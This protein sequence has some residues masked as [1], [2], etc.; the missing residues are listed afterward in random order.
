MMSIVKGYLGKFF[1]FF[2]CSLA[3]IY[4]SISSVLESETVISDLHVYRK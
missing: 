2:I 4:W 1:S 3:L